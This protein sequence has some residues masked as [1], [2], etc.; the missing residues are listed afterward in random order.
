MSFNST[1]SEDD[2]NYEREV[3]KPS[4]KNKNKGSMKLHQFFDNEALDDENS[5]DDDEMEEDDELDDME[6][7]EEDDK[8]IDRNEEEEV[9]YDDFLRINSEGRP[10]KQ[11]KKNKSRLSEYDQNRE[12][13]A[14][15]EKNA[16]QYIASEQYEYVADEKALQTP[17]KQWRISLAPTEGGHKLFLVYVKPNK[18]AKVV[19]TLMKK[20]FSS[21]E[22]YGRSYPTVYS[23]FYTSEGSGFIFVE[24]MTDQE[25]VRFRA[26]IPEIMYGKGIRTVPVNEMEGCMSVPPKQ[27]RLPVGSFV[28]IKKDV[29]GESYKGD[30]AQVVS[31]NPNGNTA[32]IK[33]VPRIDYSQLQQLKEQENSSNDK[34]AEFANAIN[35][36]QIALTKAR[37]TEG[38]TYRPPQAEFNKE[39]VM[40]FGGE[41]ETFKFKAEYN[42]RGI[43]KNKRP[44]GYKWDNTVFYGTFAYK[45]YKIRDI[46]SNDVNPAPD[47]TKKF[48]DCFT[49]QTPFED[50]ISNFKANMMSSLG[51]SLYSSFQVDDV[52]RVRT[53]YEFEG[54]QVKVLKIEG[55]DITVLP[56]NEE[57]SDQTL[58]LER[59]SL[60]KFFKEGDRVKILNGTH[61]GETGQVLSVDEKKGTA[62]ILIDSLQYA[63]DAHLAQLTLTKDVNAGQKTIGQ[64]IVGDFIRLTDSSNGVI[65]RIENK[66]I[67]VL[68]S[69]GESRAI[70]LDNIN[71]KIRD[72]YARDSAGKPINVGDRV[73][74]ESKDQRRIR[75]E[76]KHILPQY[77]FLYCES[78][79][80]H[81]GIMVAEPRECSVIN[82]IGG[83]NQSMLPQ[84]RLT[85]GPSRAMRRDDLV[86]KTVMITQGPFKNQ[87]ADIKEA[88][89]TSFRVALHNSGKMVHLDPTQEEKENS[90]SGIGRW[91]FIDVKNDPFANV[92]K[93]GGTRAASRIEQP[94][95]GYYQ[96]PTY[97]TETPSY[98]Y[99]APQEYNQYSGMYGDQYGRDQGYNTTPYTDTSGGASPYTPQSASPYDQ[100]QR[101]QYGYGY[102]QSSASPYDQNRPSYG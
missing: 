97:Q 57:M 20:F 17:L 82:A 70:T 91:K 15:Y 5:G 78:V 39:A 25:V 55:N 12:I 19:Y 18:E 8:F 45:L 52:V 59:D 83:H 6:G 89:K 81:T 64:Y 88:T 43:N 51:S 9:R 53:G 36:S 24:A 7:G 16:S 68:L 35:H 92:F 66:T 31:Y 85:M 75:A 72:Q 98:P 28:R 37:D 71:Q 2:E 79:R 46:Q 69:T 4:H 76:V 22:N 62:N 80:E 44:S 23:A 50:N 99:Q 60:E 33:L 101:Y 54:L 26:D 87:L 93:T 41:P 47:E 11:K 30:L 95:Q 34:A 32:L 10:K 77:V 63:V 14:R 74:I 42:I 65:W 73:F 61:Q 38:K 67:Y 102:G 94:A 21:A 40:A 90:D 49:N 96:Q 86:G 13:A 58:I 27:T 29:R 100:S 84:Q 3:Q 48:L 1:D 56:T